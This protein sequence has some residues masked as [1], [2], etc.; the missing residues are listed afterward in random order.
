M[1]QETFSDRLRWLQPSGWY[2]ASNNGRIIV[3]EESEDG[4]AEVSC[5]VRGNAF[6]FRLEGERKFPYLVNRKCADG[7]ILEQIAGKWRLHIME[8]KTTVDSK[9]WLKIKLQFEGALLRIL[10][11]MG[12]L[13]ITRIEKVTFYTAY[14]HDRLN[15]MQSTS[16]ALLKAGVGGREI[17]SQSSLMD[18]QT[19]HI[20]VLSIKNAV[21]KK[22]Q[23]NSTGKA[24]INL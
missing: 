17:A 9:N 13:G 22:I 6:K 18:W 7:V 11:I 3:C 20:H 8:C 23:L 2:E 19:G 4:N 16:P 14:R 24:Q 1:L 5:F 21:H 12:I 10:A 15:P